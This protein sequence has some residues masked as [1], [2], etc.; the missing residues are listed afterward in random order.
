MNVII[1][2]NTFFYILKGPLQNMSII[3]EFMSDFLFSLVL[4]ADFIVDIFFF[5]TAF[6]SSYFLLIR[7]SSNYG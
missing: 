3:E 1:L 5:I 4:S 6:I 2:G 7:L